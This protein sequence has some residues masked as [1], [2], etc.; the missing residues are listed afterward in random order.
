[1]FVT[2]K[3]LTTVKAQSLFKMCQN[4]SKDVKII[5]RVTPCRRKLTNHKSFMQCA[6][7]VHHGIIMVLVK[8]NSEGIIAQVWGPL[9]GSRANIG[10]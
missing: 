10:I 8:V 7:A 6:F 4:V 2:E 9:V 3:L 1:M 5:L